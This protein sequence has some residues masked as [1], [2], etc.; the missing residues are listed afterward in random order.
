M[1]SSHI[2]CILTSLLLLA[3][4]GCTQLATYGEDRVRDLS[5]V[6][7]MRYGTGFG[8]GVGVQFS[9]MFGTG[10]G[11]SSEWYQRQWFGRKSVVVRDG[12]FAQGLIFG[13]DGDYLRRE[14][15][16]GR[17][18]NDSGTTGRLSLFTLRGYGTSSARTGSAEWF[19][20][21]GGDM[22]KL[23]AFRIGG[24]V[25][26][27]GVNGGLY[28]NVGEVMD[29]ACGLV[30]YDLMSDDGYPKFFT[31][32]TPELPEPREPAQQQHATDGP[33]GVPSR[34]TVAR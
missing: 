23:D 19:T 12:L 14:I 20:T 21:P 27:P 3:C 9:E 34:Q 5:D 31:P 1:R 8:L 28:L 33:G 10:L 18:T 32:G 17:S 29:F 25:F 15:L 7:D 6:I 11:C 4:Q 24:A 16:D 13:Y 26:L 22:P 2:G 30:G